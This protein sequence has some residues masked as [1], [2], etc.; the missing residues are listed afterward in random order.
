M[1]ARLGWLA[2]AL[3]ALGCGD[4]EGP[5]P[6][7]DPSEARLEDAP[8]GPVEGRVAGRAWRLAD[9]RFR[10]T[11]R[12]RRERVD[13]F[14][15]DEPVERCGLPIERSGTAVWIRFAERTELDPTEYLRGRDGG[16]FEIHYEVPAERGFTEVHRGVGAIRFDEVGPRSIRGRLHLCFADHDDSC[17]GG[18]FEAAPCWSRVDGR[19]LREPPGL[20]DDA[21]EPLPG[22]ER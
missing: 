5:A 13:L 18:T 8:S 16:E 9:A 11:R 6:M 20:R 1:T 19:A 17:V 10:V 15:W 22:E 2:L 4:R 7:P 14:L 3:A 12:A 21:L